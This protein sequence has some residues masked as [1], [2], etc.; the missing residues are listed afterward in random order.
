MN[1]LD[2]TDHTAVSPRNCRRH[3]HGRHHHRKSVR[4]TY[5][6]RVSRLQ[7]DE[8]LVHLSTHSEGCYQQSHSDLTANETAIGQGQ[9]RES[10]RRKSSVPDDMKP[11]ADQNTP[12]TAA[13]SEINSH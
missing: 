10:S 9:C 11:Q 13:E 8:D 3:K 12:Q 4:S 5:G 7:Q 2:S 1:S 6:D